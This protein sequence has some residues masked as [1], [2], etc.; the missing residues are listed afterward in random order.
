MKWKRTAGGII[1]T[2]TADKNLTASGVTRN[3]KS[4]RKHQ[5]KWEKLPRERCVLTTSACVALLPHPLPGG[6]GNEMQQN[7]DLS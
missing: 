4:E 6:N 1:K 5:N 3:R 7:L 2:P